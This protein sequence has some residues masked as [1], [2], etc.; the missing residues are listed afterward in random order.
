MKSLL[1]QMRFTLIVV[2]MGSS[3]YGMGFEFEYSVMVPESDLVK[4]LDSLKDQ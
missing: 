4:A 2:G 3:L 1:T